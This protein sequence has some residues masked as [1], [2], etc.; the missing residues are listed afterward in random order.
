MNVE[1]QCNGK[2]NK[3]MLL[4]NLVKN[5]CCDEYVFLKGGISFLI[6][7]DLEV[8]CAFPGS[9]VQMVSIIGLSYMNQIKE[10]RVEV[11]KNEV[12]V[13]YHQIKRISNYL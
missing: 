1:C 3:E 6:S 8:K 13:C 4:K 5:I 12:H 10:M 11:A 2:Y 9:F 7:D